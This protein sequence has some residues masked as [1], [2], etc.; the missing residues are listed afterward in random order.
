[1]DGI[2][3]KDGNSTYHAGVRTKAWLKIKNML[4]EDCYVMG[5]TAP[6]GSRKGFGSLILGRKNKNEWIFKGHVGTGFNTASIK[7]IY[8]LLQPLVTTENPFRK[9]VPVNDSPTWVKPVM[10]V[11]IS[12]TEQT[13]EGIF[14]HP[15]F[16]RIR[17]D[18]MNPLPTQQ[19]TANVKR[20]ADKTR[21]RNK[22]AFT[23]TSKIFWP[24]EGY[25]KGDVI[26]YYRSMAPYILPHLK[27]RPLSLKRNPNGINDPGFYQKDAGEYAPEF[28]K[29]FP[30]ENEEKIIDYII[31]NN[32]AT[33]LYLAN[34]G[35]IEMN[36]WNN[37]YNKTDKPDWLALDI[38]PGDSNTFKQ[39]IQVAQATKKILDKAALTA[40]CKTSGASGIHIFIPLHAQYDYG[41]VKN[42]GAFLMQQ[43]EQMLPDITTLQRTKS[44]RGKKIYLDFLQNNRGQTLAS[45]YSIRPVPGATVSAPIKWSELK[46]TLT[47]SLFTIENMAARVKKMGDL[48][49]PVLSEKNNL[50]KALELIHKIK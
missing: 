23:N 1:L 41:I 44:K 30:Y 9:K 49:E 45:V 34:L 18:K 15:S 48:F 47:P 11:E 7:E 32:E 6:K 42:F 14:W 29:V 4:T 5:Y 24:K 35:C 43:L 12:Y 46:E 25:T 3:A 39:V 36:P 26:N 38:D 40:Y 33:L 8:E 37:R 50:K 2:I 28:V 21:G 20:P 13:R 22:P 10:I 27:D 16:L 17:D 31:C 19:K